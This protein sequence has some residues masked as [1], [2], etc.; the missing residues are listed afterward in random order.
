[1]LVGG[2]PM[3]HDNEGSLGCLSLPPQGGTGRIPLS[4]RFVMISVGIEQPLPVDTCLSIVRHHLQIC[5]TGR[6][7]LSPELDVATFQ[8]LLTGRS[9]G[10][11]KLSRW[12][13][14]V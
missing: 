13:P 14:G 9:A 11:R 4:F 12:W 8:G 1:Q 7:A 6:N 3:I 5:L 10:G 2:N